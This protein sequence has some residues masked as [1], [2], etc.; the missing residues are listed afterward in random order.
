MKAPVFLPACLLCAFLWTPNTQAGLT[1]DNRY[2][3]VNAAL[4]P[5][6]VRS[7]DTMQVLLTFHPA[8]GIHIAAEPPV[9]FSPDTAFPGALAGPISR[10]V[11]TASGSLVAAFPVREA[12]QVAV[13]TAPGIHY[14]RGTVVCFCCSD[15]EKW[16]T[17]FRQE[18]SVAFVVTR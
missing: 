14:L 8:A 12:I 4:A 17:K 1:A 13:G 6:T 18:V 5:D 9:S 16:C 15:A 2:V 10:T 11:D 3:T 7:G